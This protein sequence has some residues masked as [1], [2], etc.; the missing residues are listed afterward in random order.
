MSTKQQRRSRLHLGS[1]PSTRGEKEWWRERRD[2]RRVCFQKP[3]NSEENRK[4]RGIECRWEKE[5]EE[6][7]EGEKETWTHPSLLVYPRVGSEVVGVVLEGQTLLVGAQLEVLRG[8][9]E[10]QGVG[11][12]R[13]DHVLVAFAAVLHQERTPVGLRGADQLDTLQRGETKHSGFARAS[14]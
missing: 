5:K 3:Q 7:E 13:V 14:R 11:S 6:Q 12:Q 10:A 1:H 4:L 2:G 8:Q 9:F